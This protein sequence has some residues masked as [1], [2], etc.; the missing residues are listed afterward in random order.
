MNTKLFLLHAL[1]PLH[2]GTGRGVGMI[3]MPIAREKVTGIPYIPGSSI[4]GVLRSASKEKRDEI[5]GTDADEKGNARAGAVNFSDARILLLPVRSLRG[6]FAWATSPLLLHRFQR[7]MEIVAGNT[8]EIPVP[9]LQSEEKCFVSKENFAIQTDD[10]RVILEDL[11][12]QAQKD[13]STTQWAKVLGDALF[14]DNE[15]WRD[16]LE[17][18][19]CILPDDAM[20]FLLSTGTEVVA[21]IALDDEAKVVKNGALWYEESL[22]VESVLYG[23]LSAVKRELPTEEIFATINRV[24]EKPLQIGGSATVGRG[25]CQMRLLDEEA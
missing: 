19:L 10:D 3:D 8:F 15:Y 1:S 25:L 17:Q 21:R 7:D 2:A 18:R 12:F 24:I 16:A 14:P 11:A 22:P 20:G 9:T 4:K 13:E 6:T 23:L 5:F